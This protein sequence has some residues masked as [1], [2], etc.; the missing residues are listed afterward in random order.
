MLYDLSRKVNANQVMT[1][2]VQTSDERKIKIK[3]KNGIQFSIYANTRAL[4][5]VHSTHTHFDMVDG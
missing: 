5:L 1:K 4:N 3:K 2:C